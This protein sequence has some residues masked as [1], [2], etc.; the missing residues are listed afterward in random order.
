[1]TLRITLAVLLLGWPAVGCDDPFDFK[2]QEFR[3]MTQNVYYGFDT[4]PLLSAG[5]PEEIPVLAAQAF[6]QLLSTDF[7]ERAGAIADEIARKKPHLVGLQEVALFRI[8][9]PG[10]AVVGGTIPAE[11]VFLD[12]LAILLSALADRGL[13][14]RVAA[15]VQNVDVELP[16]VTGTDPL[17]FDDIRLTDFDVILASKDV[18]TGSAVAV[19]YQ[20]KLFIPSLGLEVPR[21]YVAVNASLPGSETIR[22]VTTHLED[23]PFP[24][25]QD[26]QVREL[27]AALGAE[28]HSVVL[29]GDFNSPAPEGDTYKFLMSQGFLD[30]WSGR[31]GNGLTWG[32]AADLRNTAVQFTQRL[33]LILIR[34]RVAAPG[35]WTTPFYDVNVWGDELDERSASGLWASDHAGVE[36]SMILGR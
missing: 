1:M 31:S 3:V 8:Q 21:G 17:A 16:M 36:A 15:K 11:T 19:N 27:A 32:H 18:R 13:E 24:E 33:D 30:A 25:V 28:K 20:S 2:F 23:T 4:G 10:D 9:S 34:E 29:V 7:P 22:F 14:Y 5:S 12:Y 6:A 26:A 35:A